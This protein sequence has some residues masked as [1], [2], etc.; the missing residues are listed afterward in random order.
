MNILKE[1]LDIWI[2]PTAN[3]D[4]LNIV[5]SEL[6]VSYRKNTRDLSPEGPVPNNIFD[7]DPSIG[8]DV[9]GVDLNRNFD[10]NWVFG[11]TL[12]PDNSGYASHYDYYKGEEPFSENEAIAIRDLAL[13]MTLFFN[14]MA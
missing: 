11:D 12:E 1:N 6:D 4:G 5:H 9:D 10:F 7:Y 8:N 13:H 14:C 3:P 2:I